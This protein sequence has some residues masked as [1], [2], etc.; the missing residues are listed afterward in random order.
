MKSKVMVYNFYQATLNNSNKVVITIAAY[1]RSISQFN[2]EI[3]LFT[4][5]RILIFVSRG[6]ITEAY[7]FSSQYNIS[8]NFYLA[9]IQWQNRIPY[10][11]FYSPTTILIFKLDPCSLVILIRI[12]APFLN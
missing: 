8:I 5:N 11:T 1:V 9:Y 7:T 3:S 4:C 6:Y 12:L 10:D 2:A